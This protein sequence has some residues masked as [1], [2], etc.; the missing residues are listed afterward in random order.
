MKSQWGA[1]KYMT[2][3]YADRLNHRGY[4]LGF[5]ETR[6]AYALCI[7]YAKKKGLPKVLL[8]SNRKCTH[9][10]GLYR[11]SGFTEI[12]VDKEKFPFDRADIAFEMY[13]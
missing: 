11:K 9:A 10:I 8:C 4:V 1:I 12:P 7:D 2:P 5:D 3:V 13:L 6:R